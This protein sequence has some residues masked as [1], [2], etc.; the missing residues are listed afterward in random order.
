LVFGGS[1]GL[2]ML[3]L[4]GETGWQVGSASYH[5]SKLNGVLTEYLER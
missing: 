1:V 3:G 5:E 4:L 2:D